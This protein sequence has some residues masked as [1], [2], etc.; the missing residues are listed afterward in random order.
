VRGTADQNIPSILHTVHHREGTD[1]YMN[2]FRAFSE[3]YK[4]EIWKR[5]DGRTCAEFCTPERSVIQMGEPD[6]G[7][8]FALLNPE[9][10]K[11]QMC[12]L[13]GILPQG[14]RE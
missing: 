2:L 4:P 5:I 8:Q 14:L 6:Q 1:R 10:W 13:C 7:I 12:E 3:L 11:V 9:I